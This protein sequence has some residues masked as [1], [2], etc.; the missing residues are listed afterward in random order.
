MGR[1]LHRQQV[2]IRRFQSYDNPKKAEI[3][4]AK[5]G[6]DFRYL[7]TS[8]SM[9]L[10]HSKHFFNMDLLS[11]KLAGRVLVDAGCGNC[12]GRMEQLA[13]ELGAATYIGV[14]IN[15]ESET[16]HRGKMG[17][18]V[19]R[20][21]MLE[22]ISR[23][24]A[25]SANFLLCGIDF[26]RDKTYRSLMIEEMARAAMPGGIIFGRGSEPVENALRRS[27]VFSIRRDA[28]ACGFRPTGYFFFEKTQ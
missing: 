14:D 11:K 1:T 4:R 25:E 16:R 8:F 26:V 9:S 27:K 5:Q 23:L 10:F 15:R 21:D 18:L 12:S 19:K 24:P 6:M 17:I 28:F 20:G 13:R 2:P 7:S 22:F 3:A